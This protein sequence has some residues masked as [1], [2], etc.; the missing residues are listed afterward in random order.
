MWYFYKI[1]NQEKIVMKINFQIFCTSFIPNLYISY[2]FFAFLDLGYTRALEWGI[3]TIF[4][5]KIRYFTILKPKRYF[6][7]RP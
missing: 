1:F 4:S 6:C 3:F 2:T 5:I 7:N